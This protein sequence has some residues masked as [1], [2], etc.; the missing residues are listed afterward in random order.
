MHFSFSFTC[1]IMMS[2]RII[3]RNL[4]RP[5]DVSSQSTGDSQLPQPSPVQENKGSF[6]YDTFN[7]LS[8]LPK[9]N[10]RVF[11][12]EWV[13]RYLGWCGV[14]P[15]GR[16]IVVDYHRPRAWNP[17]GYLMRPLLRWLEPYAQQLWQNEIQDMLP[18]SVSAKEIEK[19]T[20]FG[21]LYQRV[22]IHR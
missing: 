19:K 1:I 16:I 10:V 11:T 13:G 2:K 14:K 8:T 18:P 20:M 9:S 15:G 7:R 22:V 5:V 6:D 17:V 4:D 12:D 3:K 21:G